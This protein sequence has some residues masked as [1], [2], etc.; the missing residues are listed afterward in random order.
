MPAVVVPHAIGAGLAADARARLEHV[1]YTQFSLFDRGNY[2]VARDPA[3]P[4]LLGALTAIASEIS[5]RTLEVLESRALRLSP[6]GYVLLR[7]DRVHDDRPVELVLDL[8]P[9]PTLGAEVHFRHRGQVF[10]T[11]A[12][13]PGTLAIVER[14]PTVMCNHTYVSKRYADASVVRLVVLLGESPRA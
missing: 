5:G 13:A 14:G 12:S 11:V 1:G 2:E 9:A 6:G 3:E 10:F 7:H 4:E 8:S